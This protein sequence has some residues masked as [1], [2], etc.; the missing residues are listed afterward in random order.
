MRF[1]VFVFQPPLLSQTWSDLEGNQQSAGRPG[2]TL[3]PLTRSCFLHLP[4]R[5]LFCVASPF[6]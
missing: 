5:G 4:Q 2:K 6:L 3:R 1:Y